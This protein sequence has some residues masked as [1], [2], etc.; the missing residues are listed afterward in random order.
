MPFP[1]KLSGLGFGKS[2][3]KQEDG[4]AAAAAPAASASPPP[5][6]ANASAMLSEEEI[7]KFKEQ[8]AAEKTAALERAKYGLLDTAKTAED[9]FKET[10]D[11]LI[12]GNIKGAFFAGV[13]AGLSTTKS[14]MSVMR[15]TGSTVVQANRGRISSGGDGTERYAVRVYEVEGRQPEL[16]STGTVSLFENVRISVMKLVT[17]MV[18]RPKWSDLGGN[19]KP[20]PEEDLD[21]PP[22]FKWAGDW[23]QSEWVY[24]ADFHKLEWHENKEINDKVKRRRWI[25]D[26]ERIKLEP[27]EPPEGGKWDF[28]ILYAPNQPRSQTVAT[29]LHFYLEEGNLQVGARTTPKADVWLSDYMRNGEDVDA[30]KHGI[31]NSRRLIVVIGADGDPEN[32]FMV[33]EECLELMRFARDDCGIS[34]QPVCAAVD[35]KRINT[36]KSGDDELDEL[37]SKFKKVVPTIGNVADRDVASKA[38]ERLNKLKSES[39]QGGLLRGASKEW[40]DYLLS[41]DFIHID[42]TSAQYMAAGARQVIASLPNEKPMSGKWDFF[43]SHTQRD[44]CAK[45]MAIN[46]YK[47]LSDMGYHVWLDVKMRVKSMDAMEEGVQFSKKVI[48][49]ITAGKDFDNHYFSRW[50]C[51]QELVW[52]MN[53]GTPVVSVVHA[54]DKDRVTELL[55]GQS[56]TKDGEKVEP[57]PNLSPDEVEKFSKRQPIGEHKSLQSADDVLILNPADNDAFRESLEANF[58]VDDAPQTDADGKTITVETLSVGASRLGNLYK[59]AGVRKTWKNYYFI[60]RDSTLYY[61]P[62]KTSK[63]LYSKPVH[64]EGYTVELKKQAIKKRPY[65]VTLK[66]KDAERRSYLFITADKEAAEG[67]VTALRKVTGR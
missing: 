41:R 42:V 26:V 30:K 6:D 50:M 22:Y 38:L 55:K 64:L 25:R 51:R 29:E 45:E 10:A 7:K 4:A 61:F 19:P 24:A 67:W 63:R 14:G 43:L 39:G 31:E 17:S 28:F 53:Y 40:A 65:G 33:N 32:D 8:K 18:D 27:N 9:G 59:E 58:A 57:P 49:I 62:S 46:L 1:R 12:K 11:H 66:H 47:E 60:L 20:N 15:D 5:V 48:A 54:M 44:P 56:P 34:I 36:L 16:H 21:P 37:I 2:K 13:R 52:A 35:K 3:A 23:R